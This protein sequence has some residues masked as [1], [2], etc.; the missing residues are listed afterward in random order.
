MRPE[1][2]GR[3]RAGRF[4]AGASGNPAGRPPGSGSRSRFA[5][6]RLPAV[7]SAADVL[8]ASAAIVAAAADGRLG[9]RE[10]RDFMRLLDLHRRAIESHD[11]AA[12]VAA[13]EELGR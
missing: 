6:L 9:V 10:S 2:G 13:L 4:R 7:E 12:R 5:G 8:A 1:Q 3:D 11:L